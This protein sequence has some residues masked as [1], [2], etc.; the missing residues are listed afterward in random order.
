MDAS[1]IL[2]QLATLPPALPKFHALVDYGR[3]LYAGFDTHT[4]TLA[5]T[6]ARTRKARLLLADGYQYEVLDGRATNPQPYSARHDTRFVW[7]PIPN[8]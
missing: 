6:I 4:Q 5:E 3:G 7:T 2:T 1:A 8:A